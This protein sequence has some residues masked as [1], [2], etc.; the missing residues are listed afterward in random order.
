MGVIGLGSVWTL[1]FDL[2]DKHIRD[3][4]FV[5]DYLRS[6]MYEDRAPRS[7]LNETDAT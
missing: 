5:K 1:P 6:E 4:K 2:I 3:T 7:L